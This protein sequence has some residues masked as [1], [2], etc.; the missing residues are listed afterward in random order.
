MD[1]NLRDQG[2]RLF[3]L[4]DS[5]YAHLIRDAS[6]QHEAAALLR[7]DAYLAWGQQRYGLPASALERRV[8]RGLAG[9]GAGRGRRWGLA[10]GQ[11][12]T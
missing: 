12:R 1:V 5:A 4:I 8:R 11:Q 6:S 7:F 2:Y 3:L 9:W 10:T